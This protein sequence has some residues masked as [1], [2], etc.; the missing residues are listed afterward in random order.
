MVEYVT[1]IVKQR[2]AS[3]L[4]IGVGPLGLNVQVPVTMHCDTTKEITLYLHMHWN[5]ENGPSL[6]GFSTL[7]EKK[8]FQLIISC[9]G[10]G[11]KIALAV[12]SDLGVDRFVDAIQTNNT[13]ALSSVSGIGAKKA[14]QIA[15]QLKHKVADL[16]KSGI[17]ITGATAI[18]WHEITQVLESLNYSRGE[19]SAAMQHLSSEYA[20]KNVPFDGLIR[21]ALSFLSKK[22]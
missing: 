11:P 14:E 13:T 22:R 19:I 3:H 7:V 15:V 5:Q 8:V 21:H 12:L 16:L 20:N 18:K 9:S 4:V 1:G 6:Y 17:E 10:L 2:D